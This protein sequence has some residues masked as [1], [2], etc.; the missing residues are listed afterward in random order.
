MIYAK[1]GIYGTETV[2]SVMTVT[3]TLNKMETQLMDNVFCLTA[4]TR[5]MSTV[6]FLTITG[7]V[8]NVFKDFTLVRQ[9]DVKLY[10]WDA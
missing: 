1:H 9:A 2:I 6:E 8:N 10:H 3:G 5:L 7:L 4:L